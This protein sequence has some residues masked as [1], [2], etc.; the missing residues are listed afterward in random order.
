[1][2]NPNKTRIY[3]MIEDKLVLINAE[4][5]FDFAD[6]GE[7]DVAAAKLYSLLFIMYYY[8]EIALFTWCTARF[9]SGSSSANI[10]SLRVSILTQKANE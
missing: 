7:D 3:V 4:E 6:S 9:C 10:Q 8:L 2:L 1:M 5:W